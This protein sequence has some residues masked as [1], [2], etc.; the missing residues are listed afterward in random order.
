MLPWLDDATVARIDKATLKYGR[1]HG[2][3]G[4]LEQLAVLLK[5]DYVRALYRA[6]APVTLAE[7]RRRVINIKL[8]W[9][10]KIPLA[11]T[12]WF[13]QRVELGDLAIF[14]I[15]RF[16]TPD[17]KA[18]GPIRAR[19]VLAQAKVVRGL[20]R[21]QHPLIPAA[22]VAGSTKR[23]LCLLSNWPKFD[24]YKTSASDDPIVENIDLRQGV[25]GPLPYAW[26]VAAPCNPRASLG[27]PPSAFPSWW[28]AGP[29][30][31]SD[32]F[33][34]TFGRFVCTFLGGGKLPTSVGDLEVGA[35][36]RCASYPPAPSGGG[37]PRLCADILKLVEE[38][39]FPQY[40]FGPSKKRIV[41]LQ[42]V[43]SDFL[44]AAR[45]P[46]QFVP[47]WSWPHPYTLQRPVFD[48]LDGR[49]WRRTFM[50]EPEPGRGMP[51][52]IVH[53]TTIEG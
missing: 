48:L 9:I 6:I 49:W 43:L 40:I 12:D 16:A 17:G 1:V 35:G 11:A 22:R 47:A 30:I 53:T 20:R 15:D 38:T 34:T 18:F 7:R 52:L 21:L 2:T 36:F 41:E 24:L 29:P 50:H 46:V 39:P 42:P 10:D 31:R 14:S 26:Y 51:V 19:G 27:N 37:W 45:G 3:L 44:T 4:E 23:E 8:A 33:A 25:V 13:D 28:M 5:P 32:R